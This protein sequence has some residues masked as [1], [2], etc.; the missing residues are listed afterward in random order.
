MI[1]DKSYIKPRELIIKKFRNFKDVTMTLGNKITVISGQNGSGK[2]NILSLIASGSGVGKKAMMGS[3]FQP[4]FSEYFN[5]D[6]AEQFDK[7]ELYLKYFDGEQLAITKKLSFK[8]DSSRGRGIRIIPRTSKYGFDFRT[9][10]DTET[11]IKEKYGIGGAARVNI[12][13]IYLSLSRLY[14]L[15]ENTEQVTV[16]ELG[17]RNAL[18][19]ENVKKQ[20]AIWYN[21][22]IP[23]S[24][25][26]D[27]DLE[28]IEK[29][30]CPRTSLH[31]Q[32]NDTPTLSQSVGQDNI[33]NIISAFI[34][35][36][37]LS[38]MPDYKGALICIDE[39]DVSL[40]PA[41]Q[42]KLFELMKKLAEELSIQFVVS[43]H[44]LVFLEKSLKLES[45]NSND[46]STI[47]LENRCAPYVSKQKDFYLLK[48]D[49]FG[50]INFLKPKTNVYFEDEVGKKIFDLLVSAFTSIAEN[51]DSQNGT[52]K[53][54]RNF[55]KCDYAEKNKKISNS[56]QFCG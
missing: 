40:H 15:G 46:Y 1:M 42:L 30:A 2:S 54:M 41:T 28:M 7:Y 14:P 55:N 56:K 19:Q 34:D 51:I 35:V 50:D 37:L 48:A 52:P 17:K 21:F 9:L 16:K 47:Y 11:E 4:E 5:I 36:Y 53:K 38:K 43:S 45:K 12:P 18:Y 39:I 13:T 8:D 10:K 49:M 6:Q 25:S 31:M 44:S 32:L 29:K 23:D 3:N 22:L 20:F 27:T 24:I 26:N 33:G